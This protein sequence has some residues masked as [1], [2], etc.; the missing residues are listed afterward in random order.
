VNSQISENQA[1]EQAA[2]Q[3][4]GQAPH[5]R[6]A[7]A[8]ALAVAVCALLVIG[9][10]A[11]KSILNLS[12][13]AGAMTSTEFYFTA[14]VLEDTQMVA[15]ENGQYSLPEDASGTWNLYGGGEHTLTITLQN[16]Y[17]DLR[18]TQGE[19]DYTVSLVA[20]S[21][22][23]SF[24]V[25]G[26]GG[27][28][29]STSDGTSNPDIATRYSLGSVNSVAQA[30]QKLSLKIDALPDDVTEPKTV[31]VMVKSSAP[32]EKTLQL[33]FNVYPA[34]SG[35]TYEVVDSANSLYAELIIRNNTTQ[36]VQSTLKWS[37]ALSIDNTNELT[38]TGE[39]G[40]FNQQPDINDR[41]MK[42]SRTLNPK[43][44]VSIYFFKSDNTNYT[45]AET[46][47][48]VSDGKCEIT[49]NKKN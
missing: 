23:A 45:T 47:V 35:V 32:Y 38:F 43:E 34:G 6:R 22:G 5:R 18:I 24:S 44:S 46:P 28:D 3:A 31:K 27:A 10:V 37:D 33:T 16:Y 41:S 49:I 17:D 42:L 8:L 48:S 20:S 4:V 39:K 26:N 12:S 40:T 15:D 14:N 29:L 19:I 13:E 7:G 21:D 2:G 1:T 9:V 25:D 36:E 11:A 30:T